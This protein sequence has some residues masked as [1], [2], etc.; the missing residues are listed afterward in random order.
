MQGWV[1]ICLDGVKVKD[2]RQQLGVVCDRVDYFQREL[3]HLWA[4]G[5]RDVQGV[6]VCAHLERA[7]FRE[8]ELR[9]V[10][11]RR[12]LVVLDLERALVQLRNRHSKGTNNQ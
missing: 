6:R 4:R 8:V 10:H 1:G 7:D 2:G 12:D 9:E 5:S 11:L 3:A